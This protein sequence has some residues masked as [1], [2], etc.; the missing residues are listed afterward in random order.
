MVPSVDLSSEGLEL[1][2]DA[3][4]AWCTLE[5]FLLPCFLALIFLNSRDDGV[6]AISWVARARRVRVCLI[7]IIRLRNDYLLS[8]FSF[9]TF[10]GGH[11]RCEVSE[12]PAF[13]MTS[14][15]TMW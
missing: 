11:V 12:S 2:D 6:R 13:F 4:R 10:L 1:M 15:A 8:C 14:A 7:L 5:R 3:E 9:L